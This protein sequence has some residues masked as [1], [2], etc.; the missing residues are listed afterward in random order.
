MK[1]NWIVAEGTLSRMGIPDEIIVNNYFGSNRVIE[2]CWFG[3]STKATLGE[4]SIGKWIIKT[5]KNEQ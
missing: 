4:C 3:K 1:E 2:F 5:I